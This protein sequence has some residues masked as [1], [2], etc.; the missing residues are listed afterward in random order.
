MCDI[1]FP[2]DSKG[3]RFMSKEKFLRLKEARD[4]VQKAMPPGFSP[5]IALVLGTGLGD[6]TSFM[7]LV[8]EMEYAQIPHFPLSTVETHRGRVLGG[9]FGKREV[10]V[11]QGRVHLYEGYSPFDVC[12]G[13]RLAGL[14]GCSTL[15][16]TNAAGAINP[17]FEKGRVMV[18]T[19]HINF[20]GRNPLVGENIEELGERFPDMSRPY[21][22]GLIKLAQDCALSLGIALEKGVY[23]GVLGPSLE[24]PA[25]TRAFRMWG[26]DAVG[27]STVME[28]IAARHMGIK[29]LGLSCLTNKNLPDCMEETSFEDV[30]HEARKGVG[31]MLKLVE[32]ILRSM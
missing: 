12:F 13:V 29:V 24:T 9:V 7:D 19:D 3:E 21:D 10:L 17:L 15:I 5:S 26:A 2:E 18:I 8:W 28:V 32:G 11:F 20:T 4:F 14:L 27:M 16:I 22:P 6:M 31:E 1:G 30:V 23:I 25:E